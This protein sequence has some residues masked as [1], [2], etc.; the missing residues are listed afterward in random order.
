MPKETE[1]GIIFEIPGNSRFVGNPPKLYI[2]KDHQPDIIYLPTKYPF[3]NVLPDYYPDKKSTKKC[4]SKAN[5]ILKDII[6]IIKVQGKTTY[7]HSTND[8]FWRIYYDYS[9]LVDGFVQWKGE[10]ENGLT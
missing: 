9:E 3:R 1:P 4:I 7:I 10:I 5:R 6:K 2:Y 8:P